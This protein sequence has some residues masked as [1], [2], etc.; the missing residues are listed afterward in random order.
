MAK[1]VRHHLLVS[2]P[3]GA[4]IDIETTGKNE[5]EDEILTLGYVDR[6]EIIVVQRTSKSR[7]SFYREIEHVI[8]RLDKPFYAYNIEFEEKFLRAQLGLRIRGVDLFRP[9]Q[10]L[11]GETCKKW[12]KLDELVT[13]PE[14]Y[15]ELERTT[16]SDI[17]VL[18]RRYCRTRETGLLNRIIRHNQ[19]DLLREL[20]LLIHY[21]FLYDLQSIRGQQGSSSN[22]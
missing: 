18:W 5:H 13:E 4:L 1:V 22:R 7:S 20:Y 2:V 21:P 3:K 17:P 12:P 9:W 11:A 8:R 16:G 14:E 10:E 19:S 15:F 6:N